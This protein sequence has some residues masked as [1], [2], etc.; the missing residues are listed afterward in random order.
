MSLESGEKLATWRRIEP[1]A[2]Y[3]H[4]ND[5][6]K[7][8]ISYRTVVL[9][10]CSRNLYNSYVAT[11]IQ[12]PGEFNFYFPLLPETKLCNKRQPQKFMEKN[13]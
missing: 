11:N 12:C 9:Q 1:I 5:K 3:G 13:G 6:Y 10:I 7:Q 4:E 8:C 2:R